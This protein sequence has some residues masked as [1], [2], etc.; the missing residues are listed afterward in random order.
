MR[1][2]DITIAVAVLA[3]AAA[4]LGAAATAG[5]SNADLGPLCAGLAESFNIDPSLVSGFVASIPEPPGVGF[6][7]WLANNRTV[8]EACDFMS[9]MRFGLTGGGDFSPPECNVNWTYGQVAPVGGLTAL[10]DMRPLPP[11]FPDP[12]AIYKEEG[13]SFYWLFR[14][15]TNILTFTPCVGNP[16][17]ELAMAP[18][19]DVAAWGNVSQAEGPALPLLWVLQNNETN[20]LVFMVRSTLSNYEWG[21]DF[22]FNQSTGPE[23]EA[24][25]G[26]GAA[27]QSGFYSVFQQIWPTAKATLDSLIASGGTLPELW[28][29]GHCMGSA[30]GKLLASAAQDY[31]NNQLGDQA[32]LINGVFFAPPQFSSTPLADRYNSLVNSRDVDFKADLISQVPCVPAMPA[33]PANTSGILGVLGVPGLDGQQGGATSW[34]YNTTGGSLPF[35]GKDMPE[36]LSPACICALGCQAFFLRWR[37]AL[38]RQGHARGAVAC[39]RTCLALPVTSVYMCYTSAFAPEP[40]E[41]N[42]CWLSA[43]PAGQLGSQCPGFPNAWLGEGSST[44][45][46]NPAS[47]GAPFE[48]GSWAASSWADDGSAGTGAGSRDSTG[49]SG[50]GLSALEAELRQLQE[51]L[52]VGNVAPEATTADLARVFGKF[53]RVFD[54]VLNPA[55]GANRGWRV[56]WGMVNFTRLRDAEAAHAAL[57]D[58]VVPGLSA[59]SRLKLAWR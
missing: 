48:A 26:P 3:A 10:K 58:R 20:Q 32:P 45:P 31:L 16:A 47:S 51:Q 53:G 1:A 38:C 40:V 55:P 14:T 5:T 37:A 52:Q 4:P 25:F 44:A 50:T 22:R 8:P 9:L 41:N 59:P 29:A 17:A 24:V 56:Q 46:D 28:V 2:L 21:L 57:A 12:A 39:V 49:G 27:I 54:P 6:C 15:H 18:G 13:A 30:V 7:N 11:V 36:V 23:V 19:W 34:P 42:I 43:K 35:A 33:C